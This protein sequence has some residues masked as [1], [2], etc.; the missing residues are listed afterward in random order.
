MPPMK[1]AIFHDYFRTIGGAE[2]LILTLARHLKADVIT[3]DVDRGQIKKLGFEDVM[4]ISIG[5]LVKKSPFKMFHGMARF[6]F[7]DLSKG[8]DYFIFS[9]NLAPY[10]SRKHRPNLWYCHTPVRILYDLREQVIAARRDPVSRAL[11][12]AAIAL[13]TRIDKRSVARVD[14][15]VTNSRNTA[16]RIKKFLGR[17]SAIVYPPCDTS[18]FRHEE[19]GGYW[20]SVN[21]LYPE[22]RVDVQVNAFR[23]M[24]G[25]RLVVIGDYGK[26]DDAAK[27]AERIKAEKPANV[28]IAGNVSE[29][30]LIGYYARCRGLI[31]TAADEDF[32]MTAVEAMASGKPVIAVGEGGY[33]ESVIDGITGV[34]IK[35]NED[36]VI[37]AVKEISREPGEYREACL[38]RSKKFDV[39]LFL[40]KMDELLGL[41]EEKEPAGGEKALEKGAVRPEGPASPD[42][43]LTMEQ[44]G[45]IYQ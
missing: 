17:E 20:L 10:A 27:Y 7:C 21:R 39:S 16:G 24:P 29:E 37:G 12:A 44:T 5:G 6:Y 25:E 11:V 34:F 15:I 23:R 9:G 31:T 35:C 1:I 26:G 41:G 45:K 4:V 43:A 38:A 42:V 14:K 40:G 32:G 36:A 8:Y 22:K 33:L 19:D 3:T 2:K 18:R 28:A 30:E 13:L